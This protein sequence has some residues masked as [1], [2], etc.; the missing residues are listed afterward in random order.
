MTV[1]ARLILTFAAVV[2]LLAIPAVLGIIQI[3]RLRDIA[4]DLKG[5]H[6]N[7][8]VALGRLQTELADLD[9][10]L[11][12]HVATPDPA[13][14]ES[15][16]TA[17]RHTT[18]WLQ[19]LDDA[20]YATVAR[21]TGLLMDSVSSATAHVD[22]LLLANRPFQATSYLDETVDPLVERTRRSLVAIG[23]AIERRANADVETAQRASDTAERTTAFAVA[24]GL[25]LTLILGAWATRAFSHPLRQLRQATAL[26]AD[27]QFVAPEDLP[28]DRQDEIGQL[29]RSFGT[30]TQRLAE[31]DRL[32][33]EFVSLASHELKTPINVIGGY[34]ELLEEG[35]YGEANAKQ[36]EVLSLI[37]EQASTLTRLVNQLLDLSRFEAGGFQLEFRDVEPEPLLE[38]VAQSFE[39]LARQKQVDFQVEVVT[40]LPTSIK[41]D[42]DRLQHEVLSN[43]LSNAFKF[44]PSGGRVRVRAGAEHQV[45][46]I[47]VSDT[48]AGIPPEDL[49]HIFQKYYQVDGDQKSQGSG[50]GLAIAQQIIQAHGGRIEVESEV[51]HG[52]SFRITL[53]IQDRTA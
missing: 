27:G 25:F 23:S 52:T 11:R 33:A 6:A 9:R 40:P 1:Q 18:N 10:L 19:E 13:L 36:K 49:P 45:F 38:R 3:D 29:S 26:V 2:L 17:L 46:V 16:Y 14:R 41:A 15:I 8:S 30:M 47:V 12:S 53:P 42:P 21:P 28:Y 37:Q 31:L 35:L 44:T 32:K 20:G 48:G 39:A 22:S 4:V 7:A 51:G 43:L 34:A 50:L 5:R 24:A